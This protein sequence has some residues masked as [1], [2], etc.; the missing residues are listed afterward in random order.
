MKFDTESENSELILQI[1]NGEKDFIIDYLKV[2]KEA[3]MLM[4]IS[5]SDAYAPFASALSDK[6]Y[7]SGIFRNAVFDETTAGSKTKI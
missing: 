2:A 4:N 6:K 1:H 7:L 3:P 5:G